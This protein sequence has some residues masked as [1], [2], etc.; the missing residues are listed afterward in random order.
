MSVSDTQKAFGHALTCLL[1]VS[2]CQAA[3]NAATAEVNPANKTETSVRST[4]QAQ[5]SADRMRF[6][7]SGMVCEGCENSI[8]GAVEKL[9][10]VVACTASHKAQ[11]AII[12]YDAARVSPEQLS[13]TIAK[14][15]YEVG[16]GEKVSAAAPAKAASP[17]PAPPSSAN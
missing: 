17:V 4:A 8:R 5:A 1:L 3:E 13:E 15:G 2:G 7:V 10:G 6:P 11:E 9:D 12:E 14:L 16:T